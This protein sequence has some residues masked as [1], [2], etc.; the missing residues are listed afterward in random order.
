MLTMLETLHRETEKYSWTIPEG[1]GRE[2]V[3]GRLEV[4]GSQHP[5]RAG[6]RQD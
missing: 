6:G 3:A 2:H 5:H 1:I 4:H